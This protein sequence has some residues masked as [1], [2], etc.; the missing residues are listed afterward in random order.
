[1]PAL[2]TVLRSRVRVHHLFVSVK[3]LQSTD[4]LFLRLREVVVVHPYNPSTPKEIEF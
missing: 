1:M 4:K 3:P 2:S